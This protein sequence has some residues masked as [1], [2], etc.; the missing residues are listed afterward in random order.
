MARLRKECRR[1]VPQVL[2]I[3]GIPCATVLTLIRSLPGA[4]GLLATIATRRLE[5]HRG[6]IPASG[7]QDAATSRPQAAVR[8]RASTLRHLAAIAFPP[9]VSWRSRATPLSM[10][11]DGSS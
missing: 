8:P 7:Y 10:R 11:R 1:Q 6:L 5:R 3:T 9:R 2:P 4:P